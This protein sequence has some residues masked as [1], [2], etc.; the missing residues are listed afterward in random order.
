MILNTQ[1]LFLIIHI[2]ILHC[3]NNKNI[4]LNQQKSLCVITYYTA[5]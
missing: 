4:Y 2:N 1:I 5:W 3:S